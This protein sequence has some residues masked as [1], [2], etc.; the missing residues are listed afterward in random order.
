MDRFRMDNTEGYSQSDL[1]AL[2]AAFEQEL[3][4]SITDWMD[5][6]TLRSFEDHVAEQVQQAYDLYP[7]RQG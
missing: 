3:A 1:D 4:D 6:S 7:E 5:D 2:N